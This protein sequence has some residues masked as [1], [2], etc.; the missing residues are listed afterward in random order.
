[1]KYSW[2]R[3]DDGVITIYMT[4]GATVIDVADF[5][6]TP[7]RKKYKDVSSAK[8]AQQSLAESF[9]DYMNAG[10]EWKCPIKYPG[11]KE[12]CGS[13]GCGN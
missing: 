9:C 7:L 1:M 8:K 12:N 10:H 3:A 5:W 13:Y 2:N 4:D 11:C 6:L